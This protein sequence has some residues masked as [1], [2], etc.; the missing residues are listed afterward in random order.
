[1]PYS[2]GFTLH[3]WV[4]F[5][6]EKLGSKISTERTQRKDTTSPNLWVKRKDRKAHAGVSGYVYNRRALQSPCLEV[7]SS[8]SARPGLAATTRPAQMAAYH[9]TN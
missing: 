9:F 6:S 1:M 4:A 8:V 7:L 2:Q 5:I 3:Q